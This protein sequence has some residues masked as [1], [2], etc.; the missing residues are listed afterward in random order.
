MFERY[1]EKARLVIFYSRVEASTLGDSEIK[2]IHLLLGLLR[3]GKALFFKLQ[4]PEG[5]VDALRAACVKESRGGA[6]VGTSI[7]MALDAEAE[8]ILQRAAE[9]AD[10]REH[11]DI[12][13]EHLLLGSLH[14]PSKA[15]DILSEHGFSYTK[16]NARL[17]ANPPLGD[18]LDYT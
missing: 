14:V 8:S 13:L 16:V 1:T 15:K 9:E 10:A 5:K 18:T 12:D 4:L 7:D 3:E 11:K 2:A 17:S 6:R